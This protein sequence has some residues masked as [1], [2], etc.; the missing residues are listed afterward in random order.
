MVMMNG[1]YW[2]GYGYWSDDG[3]NAGAFICEKRFRLVAGEIKRNVN[4]R[5]QVFRVSPKV[6]T[7]LKQICSVLGVS[8]QI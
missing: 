6:C 5:W 7:R 8:I 1:P 3:N 2:S 4:T